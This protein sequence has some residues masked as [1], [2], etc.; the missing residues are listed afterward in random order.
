M[1]VIGLILKLYIS[2]ETNMY[3]LIQLNPCKCTTMALTIGKYYKFSL[4]IQYGMFQITF[5]FTAIYYDART[6]I[7]LFLLL[8]DKLY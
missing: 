1:T 2:K 3:W 4:I 5:C 7:F 6:F 8:S